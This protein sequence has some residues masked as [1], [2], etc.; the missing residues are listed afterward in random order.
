ML[1]CWTIGIVNKMENDI[2]YF[3]P[4][5]NEMSRYLEVEIRQIKKTSKTYKAKQ[6]PGTLFSEGRL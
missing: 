5:W 3:R 6:L 2:A 4:N 1:K